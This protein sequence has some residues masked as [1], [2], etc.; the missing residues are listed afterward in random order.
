MRPELRQIQAFIAVADRLHF[1]QAAEVVHMTQPALSRVIRNLETVVG[2]KLMERT[3]RK[4]ALTEAGK[5]FLAECRLAL[6][7]ADRAVNMARQAAA[8]VTGELRLAYNDFA[9]IGPLPEFIKAFRTA[10]SGIHLK[11]SFL[12]TAQQ[13]EALMGR[14]IDV[15][16]ML[17]GL[18]SPGF[19]ALPFAEDIYAALLPETHPL[20]TRDV[21]RLVDLKDEPFILGARETWQAFRELLVG[22]CQRFGFLPTIVQEA[23]TSEGIFGLVAS[24]A[25]ISVYAGC[26]R[27]V[28]R[29]GMVVRPLVDIPTP[30]RTC[31]VWYGHDTSPSLRRMVS[32]LEALPAARLVAPVPR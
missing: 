5:A 29:V 22:W 15:G 11:L 7:H 1:N 6:E 18:E 14:E 27:N 20:A 10:H 9:I 17:G 24:G 8:G 13:R 2:V 23:S 28:R 30:L 31:A 16:F 32:M 12:T 21:L 3:T 19:R 4:V 25:G 26:A